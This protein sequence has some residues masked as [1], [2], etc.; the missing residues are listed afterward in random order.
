[1]V[2]LAALVASAGCDDEPHGRME[3][4]QDDCY[5]CHVADYES[6]ANPRH[7]GLFDTLCVNCHT[8]TAWVPAGGVDAHDW[9]P[10]TE[11]HADVACGS[12][13]GNGYQE[14]DTSSECVSC[15]RPD[16]DRSPYPGHNVFPFTCTDC[17][18]RTAWKPSSWTHAWELTG[19]HIG[20]ECAGCHVGDPPVYEGTATEC[21]S[22]H[23]GD[24]DRAPTTHDG[25]QQYPTTCVDC[26]STDTWRSATFTHAWLLDG[27][28]SWTPCA[29]C[30]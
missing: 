27:A 22:C 9:F 17:H 23:R 21:V 29:N 14:G 3:V 8:T 25:H 6:T 28:H 12:C 18:D 24:Y 4:R 7:E 1:M 2:A 26:H 20:T 11:G 10:L 13:H 5:G 30:H 15:H 16:Y 19:S